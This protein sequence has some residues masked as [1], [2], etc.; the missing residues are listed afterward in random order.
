ML[1]F[2]VECEFDFLKKISHPIMLKNFLQFNKF[3]MSPRSLKKMKFL[4]VLFFLIIAV[5]LFFAAGSIINKIV[6]LP[7]RED[8]GE[9]RGTKEESQALDPNDLQNEENIDLNLEDININSTPETLE[10]QVDSSENFGTSNSA[11]RNLGQE[12]NQINS[13]VTT[14]ESSSVSE[15]SIGNTELKLEV[16]PGV[17]NRGVPEDDLNVAD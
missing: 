15:Q 5:I 2:G 14:S 12:S 8:T 1:R 11:D 16:K 13:Q 6:P 7:E 10:N 17:F 9:V 4:F 3:F